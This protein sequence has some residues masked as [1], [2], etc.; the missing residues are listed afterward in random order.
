MIRVI[1]CLLLAATVLAQHHHEEQLH[2]EHEHEEHH[3]PHYKFE[4]KVEDHKTGD[5]KSHR[6]SRKGDKVDGY[7]ML[8][9]ADGTI[10][11]VHYTA[12]KHA[13]FNAVVTKS[14]HPHKEEHEAKEEHHKG[15]H[16]VHYGHVHEVHK[17][18]HH[19][20]EE[21][22]LE[23]KPYVVSHHHSPSVHHVHKEVA[24]EEKEEEGEKHEENSAASIANFRH[25]FRP[26][27]AMQYH[28]EQP[29]YEIQHYDRQYQHGEQVKRDLYYKRHQYRG[30]NSEDRGQGRQKHSNY[31]VM[32]N[33]RN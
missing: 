2:H 21:H 9:E 22:H 24:H 14:G 16:A 1:S 7:Y 19:E 28:Y 11:E 12:D 3:E 5:Y 30:G 25:A 13:G 17:P 23:F 6:E 27:G 4:Y 31:Q 18:V 10:R 29:Q 8:K 32:E 26:Q 33:V 20:K 15:G